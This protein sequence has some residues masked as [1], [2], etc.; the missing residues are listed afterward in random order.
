VSVAGVPKP[1]AH[2]SREAK[3]WWRSVMDEFALESHHVALLTAAAEA[4]DRKEEARRI[5]A[6]EGAVIRNRFDVPVPH[7]AVSIENA[8]AVRMARL[9]REIGLD[10]GTAT[11]DTRTPRPGG[12]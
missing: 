6:D 7:P 9:L 1:P 12:R 8:A 5:V 2:L 4:F 10:D 11:P 3:R